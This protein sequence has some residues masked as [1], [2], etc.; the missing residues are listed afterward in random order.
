VPD[1]DESQEALRNVDKITDSEPCTNAEELVESE[2][3]K[4]QFREAKERLRQ[5]GGEQ[6]VE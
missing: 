3:L 1:Q 6:A 2:D 4:R 5:R